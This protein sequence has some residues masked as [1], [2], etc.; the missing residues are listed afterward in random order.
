MTIKQFL[1]K[2]DEIVNKII[3]KRIVVVL[4]GFGEE[5]EASTYTG[6]KVFEVL[7]NN[8]FNVIS[9]D[10]S[11]ENIIDKINPKTDIIFNCLH[12]TFGE[13]GHLSAILDYLKVP[14]TFSDLYPSAVTM[15]KLF[16]SAIAKKIGLLVPEDNI[17]SPNILSDSKIQTILKSIRGGGSIGMKIRNNEDVPDGYFVQK[18]IEGGKI[19]TLG[20][21]E[22]DT[23]YTPL[24]IVEVNLN[25]KKFYDQD[26]KYLEGFS[27]YTKYSGKNSKLIINKSIE[28]FKFLSIKGAARIDFIEKNDKIYV[29]EINSIP[30]LYED[31]NLAFSASLSDL[32]FY[33]LLVW[34]L[35]SANYK[36]I[37]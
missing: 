30:G 21:L 15:D 17:D 33:Q 32:D 16:F 4:G 25:S 28:L 6:E 9:I 26:S 7:K 22:H 1:S 35:N 34:I 27:S 8:N 37:L 5:R 2:F 23:E 14:Y 13:S 20:I 3:K 11:Q 10:P 29:L 12:G 31:S 24:E 18:F 19:I 36:N